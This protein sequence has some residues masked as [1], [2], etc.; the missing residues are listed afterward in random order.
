MSA[1]TAPPPVRTDAA[2]PSQR[3]GRVGELRELAKTTPGVLVV[4]TVALVLVSILVGLFT[5]VTVQGR[6]KALDDLT[7]RSGPLSIAAQDLYRSLSDADA[8]ANSAFLAGGLER[9]EVRTRYESDIAQAE[10]ALA[11]A[12]A[13]RE[14]ADLAD[15]RGPL[16]V[17]SRELSVYT[18]LV[19]T[20]R[21]NNR[22]KLP[23]GAAYQRA[24]SNLM[25][26]ELLPAAERLYTDETAVLRA[27]QDRAA[28]LPVVEVVLGLITLVLLF[29]AQ[30][31]VRRRTR[32][33]LNVGLLV[34]TGAAVVSLAWVLV[35]TIGVMANVN[36]SQEHGSEQTDVLAQARIA[37]LAARG[38]ETMTLVAR[39]SGKE[40][41]EGY[42]DAIGQLAGDRGL[43]GRAQELASDGTVR[44]AVRAASAAQDDWHEVH[45]RIRQLD[46]DG[47]YL[48]AV[49]LAIDPG[50]TGAATKFD[51]VDNSLREAIVTTEA[52]FEDEVGQA[53]N[54]LT[55]TVI[56]VIVLAL[57]AAAGAATGIWQ[58]LKEYR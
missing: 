50:D 30:R 21:A 19:E 38:D 37:A 39:G 48:D 35:A 22:Q 4:F 55:G 36:A 3:A 49:D 31:Y 45:Q 9:A 46:D 20:A 7:A 28:R 10:S 56:G 42:Q 23:V 12:V 41:E 8:T 32:R 58:R 44:D 27:D 11:T 2:P 52:R 17:L 43:L 13:A 29:F 40:F 16:A 1:P 57:V 26:E 54:A 18:G 14:P 15:P 53:S 47:V 6:A 34:A 5:A 33:R 51:A 24:A 25:R